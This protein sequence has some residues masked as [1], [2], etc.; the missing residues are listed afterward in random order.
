MFQYLHI[1]FVTIFL[2]SSLHSFPFFAS[3]FCILQFLWCRILGCCRCEYTF[4]TLNIVYVFVA[5]SSRIFQL[6]I[7]IRM[8]L[9]GSVWIVDAFR[10]V[11]F[12]RFLHFVSFSQN[13]LFFFLLYS[14]CVQKLVTDFMYMVTGYDD[15]SRED[16][17]L[18]VVYRVKNVYKIPPHLERYCGSKWTTLKMTTT[19]RRRKKNTLI[20]NCKTHK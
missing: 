16:P 10:W 5:M 9:Y 12:I 11:F 20:Q 6:I 13:G 4:G 17:D 8:G 1:N 3:R 14:G 2:R 7:Y 15:G 18:C 19:K